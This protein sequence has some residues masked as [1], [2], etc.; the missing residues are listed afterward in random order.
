MEYT[1]QDTLRIRS[2]EPADI[3]YF[4]A[5]FAQ[6]GW[7]KPLAQYESYYHRQ[8]EEGLI[9]LVATVEGMPAGY[10]LVQT[11]L[12]GPFVNSGWPEVCDFNVLMSYQGR[13]IGTLLLE[14]A[15]NL[16]REK[17]PVITLGVGLHSGYGAAQRLYSRRGYLL[18]GSGVWYRDQILPEQAPCYND[19]SLVLYLSK[20]LRP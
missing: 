3:P 14:T 5:A 6:Q 10:L 19:D 2:M 7:Q 11:P 9:V 18:D 17:S 13:G 16:A 15:E 8:Q 12:H 1:A 4:P 20:T